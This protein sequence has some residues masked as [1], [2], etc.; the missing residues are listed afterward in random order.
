ML[1]ATRYLGLDNLPE[2]YSRVFSDAGEDSFFLS[3]PWFHNL[4]RTILG[5]NEVVQIIGVERR[6]KGNVPVGALL[7]KGRRSSNRLM[8]QV[9]IDSLTNYYTS[10]FAPVIART[11]DSVD[12]ITGVFAR[13]LHA[14]APP[15]DVLNIRPVDLA[16]PATRSLYTALNKEGFKTQAYFCFG[17]WYLN[18]GGRSYA[19]YFESLPSILKQTIRRKGKAL[20]K[21][22]DVRIE[23]ISDFDRR[24]SAV[25]DYLKVYGASWKRP[26]PHPRFIPD[27][28]RTCAAQG[29]L[30]LGMIYVGNEPVASQLWIV[31]NKIASIFKLAYDGRFANLSVG[32]VLTARLMEHAIDVDDVRTVD[33]LT[34]DDD[35]KRDWM[36]HRRERWGILVFNPKTFW[37]KL[38][39]A[40]HIGC[41]RLQCKWVSLRRLIKD[42]VTRLNTW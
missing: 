5:P 4:E 2:P 36:S 35:Y 25:D 39:I 40:R 10:Y 37:G 38:G 23:I 8:S 30:R 28:M 26:E 3:L 9:T 12:D 17:N 7:V 6:D 14:S 22:G 32:T 31:K 13:E 42:S 1:G 24:P 18:V 19:E 16:L 41:K 21:R 11:C 34:G 27:L 29:W 15:W 20:Q 33:Y